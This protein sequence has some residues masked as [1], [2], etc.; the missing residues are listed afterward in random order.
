[1]TKTIVRGLVA[2]TCFAAVGCG[3]LDVANPN[4]P[5]NKSALADPNAIEAVAAGA[6][7]TWFN[8]YT[9]LRGA[10]VLV[11]DARSY[12]S[13]W[14]NG[15]LNTYS[16]V[17]DPTLPP[18]Q[19]TRIVGWKNDPASGQRTSIDAFWSGGLDENGDRARRLL[20]LAVVGERCAV[21]DPQERH[22]HQQRVGHEAR[23][24]H[25]R[26][27]AGRVVDDVRAQL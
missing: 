10:G 5:N 21:G 11:T 14:N 17:A 2:A 12:S 22:R 6:I 4:E 23:R 20:Q 27:H 3:S 16:S 15:N 25:R 9:D 19:W 7:R 13:S 24:D 18:D 1:M 26:V 8:A